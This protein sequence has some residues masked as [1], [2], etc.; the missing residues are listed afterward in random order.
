MDECHCEHMA[1]H[2]P[3]NHSIAHILRQ[4]AFPFVSI[5]EDKDNDPRD[6]HGHSDSTEHKP[7]NMA[8]PNVWSNDM[9]H[10]KPIPFLNFNCDEISLWMM[11]S[12]R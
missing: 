1:L 4:K 10:G 3:E 9:E 12:G 8:V 11:R 7:I 5:K 6:I 2:E